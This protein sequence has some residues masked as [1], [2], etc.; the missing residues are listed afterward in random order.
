[1]NQSVKAALLSALVFPGVGQLTI[2]YEKRGW[3]IIVVNTVLFSLIMS[4]I[5]Q[6]A[7]E[8]ISEVEKNAELTGIV[9]F[10]KILNMTSGLVDFS[11]NTFLNLV[12]ISFILGWFF[13]VIDAYRLG[14]K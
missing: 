4:G 8:I 2:G 12:L 11:D 9:D 14:K 1:M 6:K 10:E 3:I 13:S 7:Y 5:I